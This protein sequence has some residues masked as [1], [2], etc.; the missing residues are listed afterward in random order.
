[1]GEQGYSVIYFVLSS[2]CGIVSQYAA[3]GALGSF[4]DWQSDRKWLI[5][6]RDISQYVLRQQDSWWYKTEHFWLDY[7]NHWAMTRSVKVRLSIARIH[8]T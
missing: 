1:M 5:S 8:E 4:Q 6:A 2:A 7:P 3:E